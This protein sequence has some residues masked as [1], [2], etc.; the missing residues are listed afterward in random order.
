MR[1]H[2]ANPP[3]E[4]PPPPSP[5]QVKANEARAQ[6]HAERE[7]VVD[8]AFAALETR[9]EAPPLTSDEVARQDALYAE[10]QRLLRHN[11]FVAARFLNTYSNAIWAVRR[12]NSSEE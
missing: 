11:P 2:R 4:P 5:E 8:A 7:K 1:I 12:R 10:H 6:L 3:I 9:N